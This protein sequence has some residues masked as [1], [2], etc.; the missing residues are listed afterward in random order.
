MH[1]LADVQA[2]A[3]PGMAAV[4]ALIRSRLASD[5]VLINQIS[6]HI[7]S[8]GG[9]RLRPMLH[10]LAARAAGYRGDDHVPLAALIEFIHTSTLL[11]DDVV[12]ESDLRR[13]RKTANALWGNAASVLVGDF[14]YS[15]SFQMMVELDSMRI[16]RILADTTNR[17]AEGEV[18]QLLNIGNADT[19]EQAYLDVIERKTAVL[20]S[21]ATRLGAVLAGL[22]SDQEEALA[23]YGLD[24]GYAF[25]IADDVLD[26][27]SDAETLGKN[28]GDDLAE[29]KPTLPVIHA[30]AYGTPEQAAS[31]RRAIESG[32][33]D[34]LDNIVAAIRDTGALEHARARA[35]QYARSAQSALSVLPAS[36]ARDALAVLADYSVNRAS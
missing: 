36:N 10:L 17:I 32:G 4:N 15:R 3:A 31:L 9:K 8:S 21:A 27:V 24:L 20:F 13:G 26:Y 11:H 16:M 34:S 33:L 35:E 25:Q 18:L 22:P 2:L 28:I 12:D 23:R 5:V 6:E 30:I 29:G 1:S 14:L 19:S 7:I